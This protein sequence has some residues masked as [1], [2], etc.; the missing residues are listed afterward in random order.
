MQVQ[1]DCPQFHWIGVWTTHKLMH[2]HVGKRAKIQRSKKSK[3]GGTKQARQAC[4][5]RMERR[6][7]CIKNTNTMEMYLTS[8]YIQTSPRRDGCNHT[9]KWPEIPTS[10]SLQ[11]A[12]SMPKPRSRQANMD[13]Q[14]RS[15]Q[16]NIY[17][18]KGNDPNPLIQ[19]QVYGC[20]PRPQDLDL[21]PTKKSKAQEKGNNKEQKGYRS[22]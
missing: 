6:K 12:Q 15:K 10:T 11:K 17:M 21:H 8:G 2:E 22:T 5:R 1:I 20:R 4:Q 16:A 19:A 9:S 18:H 3:T 14:Y 7:V 13:I